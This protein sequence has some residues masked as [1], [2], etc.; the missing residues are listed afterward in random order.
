MTSN[1]GALAG[2][3][4]ISASIQG[5]VCRV[6]L[7][8]PQALNALDFETLD[9]LRRLLA[10]LFASGN[11]QV[12][13]VQEGEPRALVIEGAGDRAFAAGA[14]I[15]AMQTMSAS[16]ALEFARLGQAVT[17][18]LEAASAVTIAKVK[19]F[20]LGGGLELAMA[21]DLLVAARSA[22][23]GQPEVNLGLIPG[24]G[25][26]QR[27]VRRVGLPVALD[28]L[29]CGRGRSLTGEE[30]FSLGLASRVVDDDKLEA[31][32][33]KILRAV[34]GAGPR[35]VAEAKRLAR[36]AYA[37]ELRHGLEAEAASFAALF[38]GEEAGEG[39]AAFIDKRSP[40]FAAPQA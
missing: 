11:G 32:I 21:C 30:A 31:E 36:A 10:Q 39:I 18:Q 13:A 22:R 8:R 26:T 15:A 17:R 7:Q 37:M 19:G 29:L 38:D 3:K 20:A 4:A 14:D 34:L 24:F 25:G 27:L 2:Y 1:A 6:V 12:L 28:L 5:A 33:D 9:E 35:A 23:M 40:G 16:A